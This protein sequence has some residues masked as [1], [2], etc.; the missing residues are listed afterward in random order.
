M[1]WRG[2]SQSPAS[3]VAGLVS[4][5]RDISHTSIAT[6]FVIGVPFGHHVEKKV[7]SPPAM[8]RRIKRLR[9]HSP[10]TVVVSTDLNIGQFDIGPVAPAWALGSLSG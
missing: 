9:V 2:V 10:A 1:R 3:L 7:R 5:L 4:A 6:S 8:L